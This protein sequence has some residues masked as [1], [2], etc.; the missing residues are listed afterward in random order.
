MSYEFSDMQAEWRVLTGRRTTTQVSNADVKTKLNN[1]YQIQFPRIVSPPRFKGWYEFN[2]VASDEDYDLP[3]TV[4]SISGPCYLDDQRIDFYTDA[5]LF[6]DTYEMDDTDEDEPTGVLLFDR[7]L[8]VRKIPDDAYTIKLRKVSSV[9]DALSADDDTP[10]NELWG[11]VITYGSAL[12]YVSL[13]KDTDAMQAISAAYSSYLALVDAD[14]VS[15][16]P[17]G[18]RAQPKY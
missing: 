8:I 1:F 5:A 7:T 9:P 10:D 13:A 14:I 16:I 2:T 12:E 18:T 11:K 3:S 15:Q 6:Y 4:L 17:L